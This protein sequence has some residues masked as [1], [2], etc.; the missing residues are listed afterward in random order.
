MHSVQATAAKCPALGSGSEE[1]RRAVRWRLIAYAM[2][3][4]PYL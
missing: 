4:G 2:A 1:C 3:I